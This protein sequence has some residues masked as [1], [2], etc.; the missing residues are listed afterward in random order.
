MRHTRPGRTDS[1]QV[2]RRCPFHF[3]A[4]AW[5]L[6]GSRSYSHGTMPTISVVIPSRNDA[7]ML[8][9]CLAAL[10]RQSRMPD[11]IV[12]VDN[13][14]TDNT[15]AV[16]SAAGVRR[17]YL[18]LPGITGATAAGLDA[19]TGEILARLDADSV[20]PP[21]WVERVEKL[22]ASAGPLTAVTGPGD[23]YGAASGNHVRVALTATD[24][25]IT[26]AV[27]RLTA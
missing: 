9:A 5:P 16:C 10:R 23:F 25:R 17:L 6:P 15:A 7:P 20:P 14:S 13:A 11:E 3:R 19:A 2:N 27:D 24:E 8:A 26:A 4:A 21:D 12:V 18:D 1:R 22:L